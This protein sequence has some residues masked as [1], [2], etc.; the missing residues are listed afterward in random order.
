VSIVVKDCSAFILKGSI[1]QE[2]CY[3]VGATD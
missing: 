1:G 3:L 2:E